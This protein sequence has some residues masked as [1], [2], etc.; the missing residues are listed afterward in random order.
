MPLTKAEK[1]EIF[2]EFGTHPNDTGSPQVQ[3][4]MMTRRIK[5]LTEHLS[6]HKHDDHSRRGLLKLVGQRRR[7]LRYLQRTN[8][9]AYRGIL[10]RLELRR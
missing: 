10:E 6:E 1:E 9:E 2:K 3:I 8:P 7:Q 5:Q 4:A